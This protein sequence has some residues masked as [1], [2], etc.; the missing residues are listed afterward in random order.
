MASRKNVGGSEV[1]TWA[2]SDEGKAFLASWAAENEVEVPTVGERGRFAEA[3]VTAFHKANPK[4]RYEAKHVPTRQISG[5]RETSN[6][7]KIPVKV[8]ATLAEVREFAKAEGMPVGSR[9]R[10]ASEVYAA[11]A[12]RPKATV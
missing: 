8:T 2:K 3:L 1:R 4:I 6:G 5:T 11:F 12:A 7:R 10:I 9:G